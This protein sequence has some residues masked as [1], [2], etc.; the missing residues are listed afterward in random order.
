MGRSA[1]SQKHGVQSSQMKYVLEQEWRQCKHAHI[2]LLGWIE[3][4]VTVHC[5]CGAYRVGRTT[6]VDSWTLD[7]MDEEE[8]TD[9]PGQLT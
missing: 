9:L 5:T 8:Q 7:V 1:C 4:S 2:I 6:C 3:L